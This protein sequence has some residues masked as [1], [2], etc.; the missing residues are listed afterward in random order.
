MSI[1]YLFLDFETYKS[2]IL[3]VSLK[4]KGEDAEEAG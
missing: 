2:N 3:S 4:E 1:W